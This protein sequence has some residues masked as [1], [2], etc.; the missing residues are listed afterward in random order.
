[1]DPDRNF[2]ELATRFRNTIY[3][4]AR[5]RLRL[6]ALTQDFADLNVLTPDARVLDIGGGQG[7]FCLALAQQGAQIHLC[8]IS[9]EM[10][11]IANEQ[12]AENR[13]PL[14]SAHCALQD[15][16]NAFPGNFDI[17]LNHAVLEWL[18]NPLDALPILAQKVR[19][20]GWLSLMFYN[21][22]GHVWRQLM[23]GGLNDP[24]GAN[25]KLRKHGNAPQHPLDPEI[26]QRELEKLGFEIL[27]WR[28]I[29]CIHDHMPQ[30]VRER[31]GPEALADA[32]LAYG[33]KEPYRQLGRYVHF[34]ARKRH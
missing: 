10:L 29:R 2:N 12:F 32:D 3:A 15:V 7:Q 30:K 27:R 13:L 21:L 4:T 19:P 11:Q 34:L 17:V 20:D 14:H 6:A 31:V 25:P 8:D 5:G 28:G 18:E 22:H 16:D 26:L 1:M 9:Q 24:L 33:L 23:N